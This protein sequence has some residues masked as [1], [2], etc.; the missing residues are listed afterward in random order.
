[1]LGVH[2][3]GLELAAVTLIGSIQRPMYHPERMD[4]YIEQGNLVKAMALVV[5]YRRGLHGFLVFYQSPACSAKL[6]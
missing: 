1:M 4:M 5:E 6:T 3:S 2:G